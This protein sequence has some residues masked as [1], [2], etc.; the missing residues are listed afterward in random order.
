MAFQICFFKMSP[1]HTIESV[2]LSTLSDTKK[3]VTWNYYV[4]YHLK[5]DWKNFTAINLILKKK[6]KKE[7]KIDIFTNQFVN[8]EVK[9]GRILQTEM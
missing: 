3:L 4:E 5:V 6:K 2:S 1:V 8:L 9:Y 7:K